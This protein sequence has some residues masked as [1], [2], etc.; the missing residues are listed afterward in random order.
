M[1]Y[2][3]L[4]VVDMNRCC[5]GRP[6]ELTANLAQL[7][8]HVE[9]IGISMLLHNDLVPCQSLR[10]PFNWITV[11]SQPTD[12]LAASEHCQV[13]CGGAISSFCW[14]TSS[15]TI[16]G[17]G[18]AAGERVSEQCIH[19]RLCGRGWAAMGRVGGKHAAGSGVASPQHAG[20]GKA[21]EWRVGMKGQP[22]RS[23]G[24]RRL[25]WCGRRPAG[26]GPRSRTSRQHAA[27]MHC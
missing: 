26:S 13:S 16:A 7:F 17:G 24:I 3:V 1:Q 10:R 21:S 20:E 9:N 14:R 12:V 19:G 4:N 15:A 25:R 5:Y 22:P 23:A 11:D 18:G 6:L 8:L 27:A 2:L